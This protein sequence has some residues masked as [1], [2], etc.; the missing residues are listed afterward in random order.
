MEMI[1]LNGRKSKQKQFLYIMK[2]NIIN[3]ISQPLSTM[4]WEDGIYISR[5][6]NYLY[7]TY[8]PGDLLAWTLNSSD[9]TKFEPYR[10]G[11]V[12]GMDLITNPVGASSWI[13]ADILY[14][15]KSASTGKFESWILSGMATEY[16]F[17]R[18]SCSD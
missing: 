1:R 5:D 2:R 17:R 9:P 8:A 3:L 10:R 16:I 13:Q 6:G 15:A 7:C 18:C 12:F 4:G 11:P 14:S